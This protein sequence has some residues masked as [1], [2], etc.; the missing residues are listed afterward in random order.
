MFDV[1]TI[2][3]KSYTVYHVRVAA[4]CRHVETCF[5]VY[6]NRNGWFWLNSGNCVPCK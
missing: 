5:L 2:D 6:G 3:G 1:I 4:T